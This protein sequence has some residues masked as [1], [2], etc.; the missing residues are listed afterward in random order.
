MHVRR[1]GSLFYSLNEFILCGPE[2]LFTDMEHSNP[3]SLFEIKSNIS[4]SFIHLMY[5]Y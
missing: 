3:A 4:H 1:L 2:D 5:A